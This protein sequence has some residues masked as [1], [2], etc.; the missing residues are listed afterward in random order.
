ME[1]CAGKTL[2]QRIQERKGR[3]DEAVLLAWFAQ[4]ALALHYCHHKRM[5]HRDLKSENV[6]LTG[7]DEVRLGDFGVA[8]QLGTNSVI[9]RTVA[10]TY[11]TMSPEVYREEAYTEKSDMWSLGCVLYEMCELRLPF[12]ATNPHALGHKVLND[13]V[14]PIDAA[15][16]D[17]LRALVRALLAKDPAQRPSI[18]E[19]LAL[20]LIQPHA[21][22]Y[23]QRS[24][25]GASLLVV[26]AVQKLRSA[27]SSASASASGGDAKVD[28]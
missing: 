4:L 20:P 21:A 18:D 28:S 23:E 12:Q 26:E 14:V 8:R 5:M 13:E 7:D 9:A 25:R 15:F 11:I 6:Y 27:E 17:E 2:S 16:S 19:V 10:G 1:Y 22:A 24:A 3:F